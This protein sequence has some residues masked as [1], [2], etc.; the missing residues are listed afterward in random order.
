M[1]IHTYMR[2]REYAAPIV[3]APRSCVAENLHGRPA[4]WLDAWM[5][6]W[7]LSA[8]ALPY[9]KLSCPTKAQGDDGIG[10]RHDSHRHTGIT[11]T[12]HQ[13][14]DGRDAH[15]HDLPQK[16]RNGSF[17]VCALSLESVSDGGFPFV[18]AGT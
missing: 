18:M 13:H 3:P 16:L 15:T 7:M 8:E 11:S 9:G 14:Q 10:L 1:Y 2:F 4:G 12:G 6:G 5:G 17:L